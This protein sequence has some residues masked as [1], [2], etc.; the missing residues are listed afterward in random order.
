MQYDQFGIS[1]EMAEVTN[2]DLFLIKEELISNKNYLYDKLKNIKVKYNKATNQD[3]HE[4][5]IAFYGEEFANNLN[6]FITF[7]IFV[8]MLDVIKVASADKA[9]QLLG[10]YII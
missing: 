9:E 1:D 4:A 8:D 10:R 6:G 5:I 2:D 3:I 7:D